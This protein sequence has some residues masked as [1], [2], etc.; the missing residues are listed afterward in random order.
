MTK[1]S[2]LMSLKDAAAL[3]GVPYNSVWY[4]Y[5]AGRLPTFKVAG[6]VLVDPRVLKGVLDGLGYQ[7]RTKE[8]AATE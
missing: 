7:P 1:L 5:K 3:I 4:Y 2:Q 8:A 6:R